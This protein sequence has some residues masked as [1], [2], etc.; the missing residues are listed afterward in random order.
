ML[1]RDRMGVVAS[2]RPGAQGPGENP[3]PS[4]H[5]GARAMEIPAVGGWSARRGGFAGRFHPTDQ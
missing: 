1:I 2:A 5:K 4:A 3:D